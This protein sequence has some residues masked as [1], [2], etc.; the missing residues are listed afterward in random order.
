MT[1]Y[2]VDR[3]IRILIRV[4]DA[5]DH[6]GNHA[7]RHVEIA[8]PGQRDFAGE[9]IWKPAISDDDDEWTVERE[10][11]KWAVNRAVAA[12]EKIERDPERLT[13]EIVTILADLGMLPCTF[14]PTDR[15]ELRQRLTALTVDVE[16]LLPAP[17]PQSTSDDDDLLF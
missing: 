10:I 2:T 11:T 8:L 7:Y 1:D 14:S 17:P 15:T 16:S 13:S 9:P 4:G 6:E 5:A 12:E 3:D